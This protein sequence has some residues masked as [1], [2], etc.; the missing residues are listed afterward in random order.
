MLVA[1]VVAGGGGLAVAAAGGGGLAVAA[2]GGGGL[3]V[4]AAGGGGLAVETAGG[5][6]LA[7]AAAGGGG[8]AVETA[9]GGG[10]AVAAAGGGGLAVEAAGGGGLAVEAAGGGGLAVETA[11]GGGL[12]VEAAGGGGLAVEAADGGAVSSWEGEGCASREGAGWAGGC[13]QVVG[14]EAGAGTGSAWPWLAASPHGAQGMALLL[15]RV[16]SVLLRTLRPPPGRQAPLHIVSLQPAGCAHATTPPKKAVAVPVQTMSPWRGRAGNFGD[17]PRR[18]GGGVAER[19]HA[20]QGVAAFL[21]H[22][23]VACRAVVVGV[24]R[25]REA[26]WGGVQVGRWLAR[27]GAAGC[28]ACCR[29]PR[30][31]L[32]LQQLQLHDGVPSV[33][34][35]HPSPAL[36]HTHFSPT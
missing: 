20:N 17:L 23:Q 14:V 9:G 12:A 22:A 16:A 35:H 19:K 21:W 31:L 34:W 7:V 4:E 27:P 26:R 24:L 6:G 29:L 13:K 28:R 30:L 3:V 18:E 36:H 25:R 8:L 11:G 32:Q 10:L 33:T 5:G 1:D 2:A 15:P